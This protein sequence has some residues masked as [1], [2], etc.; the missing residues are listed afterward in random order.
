V[1]RVPTQWVA[2]SA[3]EPFLNPWRAARTDLLNLREIPQLSETC[4]GGDPRLLDSRV[5]RLLHRRRQFSGIAVL[6][7]DRSGANGRRQ[8]R[9][10]L[11]ARSLQHFVSPPSA[12][13]LNHGRF[14]PVSGRRC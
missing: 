3:R 9:R 2:P 6:R 12:V 14:L 7:G 5:Q 11:F 4:L 8:P 1:G 13:L 10:A